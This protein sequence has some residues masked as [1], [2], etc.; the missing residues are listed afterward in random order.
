MKNTLLIKIQA[1]TLVIEHIEENLRKL[2]NY[3][4]SRELFSYSNGHSKK[5]LLYE[6]YSLALEKNMSKLECLEEML[7]KF[8]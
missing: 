4:E 7:L 1:T 6:Y 2:R 3:F 8:N 5:Y